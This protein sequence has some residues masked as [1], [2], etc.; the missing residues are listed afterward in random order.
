MRLVSCSSRFDLFDLVGLGHSPPCQTCVPHV[1]PS[2]AVVVRQS[3]TQSGEFSTV[4]AAIN[5]L[6]STSSK[7]IFIFPGT[8][9]EQV[10]ITR[11]GPLTIMGSTTNT[12]DQKANSCRCCGSDDA[13]GTFRVHKDNLKLYNVN[14]KN[15]F[16][17]GSQAI[18]LSAYGED[19]GFYAVGLY[20]YQDT[21]LANEG[22]QFYGSCYI[23]GAVDY[24][25]GQH[26]RIFIHKS[27]IASVGAGAITAD[28][29][30]SASDNSLF[31]IDSSTV[32]QSEAAA[33]S[34][35]GQVFLGRP[36]R[37]WASVA[38]VNTN[39]DS[40]I[41]SAGW[42]EWS[43]SMPNTEDVEFVEVNNSGPG[44]EGARPS[45]AQQLD[46]DAGFTA[47]DVL[48]DDW[49]SWVDQQYV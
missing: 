40:L 9:N 6:D 18:A 27:T 20:G 13:S 34:L 14:I 32:I 44:S 16:G 36:W 37:S 42:E 17:Q 21:L 45:F 25:F 31:V 23:E 22:H 35:D 7:T 48:G 47:A 12:A 8:Y 2:G 4:Q 46:S 29:P 11:T 1:S 19:L 15:T 33:S 3:G 24:I 30:T 43:A 26:A 39:L 41:N 10:S 5:S 28:G 38:F 49:T